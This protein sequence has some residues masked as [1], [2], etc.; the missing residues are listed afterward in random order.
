MQ[1]NKIK[2]IIGGIVVCL[3]IIFIVLLVFSFMQENNFNTTNIAKINGIININEEYKEEN[4]IRIEEYELSLDYDKD[5]LINELELKNGTSIYSKDTDN[6]GLT[7]FAEINEFY[8][9][10]LESSTK[11]DGIKDGVKVYYGLMPTDNLSSEI[12][13]KEETFQNENIGV[14]LTTQ[15]INTRVFNAIETFL[16]IDK[17]IKIYKGFYLHNVE[18]GTVTIDITSEMKEDGYTAFYYDEINDD[19]KTI[20]FI[21]NDNKIIIN[22]N[23]LSKLPIVIAS[24]ETASNLTKNSYIIV[25]SK[26]P[27]IKGVNVYNL[28]N[29]L[30]KQETTPISSEE[31]GVDNISYENAG[32]LKSFIVNRFSSFVL[33]NSIELNATL[34]AIKCDMSRH[35]LTK[36][37]STINETEQDFIIGKHTFR[38][39]NFSTDLNRQNHS[40]G[41]VFI[42]AYFKDKDIPLEQ[43]YTFEEYRKTT[44]FDLGRDVKAYN[45]IFN[46]NFGNYTFKYSIPEKNPVDVIDNPDK[47][48]YKMIE[49]YNHFFFTNKKQFEINEMKKYSDFGSTITS[50]ID[51]DKYVIFG[52]S[53]TNGGIFLL[54]YDYEN[55]T[56]SSVIKVKVF[57]P[58]IYTNKINGKKI[59]NSLYIVPKAQKIILGENNSQTYSQ[60]DFYYDVTKNDNKKYYF[61]S[62]TYDIDLFL[63]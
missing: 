8:S 6:D 3:L 13:N 11:K 1:K 20:D 21:E 62:T 51:N 61:D 55:D 38:I 25:K 60:Y 45:E 17:D 41:L 48:V 26:L 36:Y 28:S 31:I 40:A 44:N 27:F 16:P 42:P 43:S 46:K 39:N 19:I 53:N 2:I 35:A 63:V 32:A 59:D 12:L 7:D 10:P 37:L 14:S 18:K 22:I 5:G 24:N 58:N 30:S 49:M 33:T 54:G 23:Q 34:A 9:N 50:Q 56:T 52:L 4:Q 47:Q 15:D 29:G 57:D